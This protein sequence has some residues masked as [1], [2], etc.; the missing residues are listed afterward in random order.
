MGNIY[1]AKCYNIGLGLKFGVIM[2]LIC[3]RGGK[4]NLFLG[5]NRKFSVNI[6]A[7]RHVT[8]D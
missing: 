1:K 4:N 5:Q 7:I 3:C 2:L 6:Q 8:I